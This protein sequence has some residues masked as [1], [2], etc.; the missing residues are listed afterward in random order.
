MNEAGPSTLSDARI[1]TVGVWHLG[2]VTSACLASLGYRVVGV[3]MDSR[4]VADLNRAVPPL[5]E[6]GL[7]ELIADNLST[8]RLLYATDME[9]AV[10]D[11]SYVMLTSDTPIDERDQV[12][13]REIFAACERLAPYLAE[14]AVLVVSSQ[15]PVG[16]CEE[17]AAVVR[18]RNAQASFGVACVPENLR[19][20][21]AIERFLHPDML[22]IGADSAATAEKVERLLAPIAAPRLNTNCGQLR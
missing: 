10:Q 9:M 1:C 20:G 7:G 17:L 6:P 19:L 15:V 2:S 16:T 3:D 5:F 4:R 13:L 21:R 12:D 14:G 22:I 18:N 11:A 8:G